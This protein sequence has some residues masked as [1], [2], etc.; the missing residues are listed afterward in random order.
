[1]NL[2]SEILTNLYKALVGT[3]LEYANQ[4]WNP[5]LKKDKTTI[6]NIQRRATNLFQAYAISATRND[7]RL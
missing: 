2:N 5:Y 6:E 1:M 3:H 7:F 4:A